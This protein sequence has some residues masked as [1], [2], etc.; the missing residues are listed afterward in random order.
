MDI[1]TKP[2]QFNG[3]AGGAFL[4]LLVYFLFMIIPIVGWAFGINYFARWIAD[5]SLINGQKI[6]FTATMGNT[7]WFFLKNMLL[8]MITFGI[9]TFWFIP[10]TYRF[11]AGYVEYAAI[12]PAVQP[13]VNPE[14]VASV[15]MPVTSEQ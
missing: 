2:L 3:T 4:A 5:N 10:R 11:M 12:E 6:K 15:E 1:K 8:V 9:F 7:F 13:V 14:P